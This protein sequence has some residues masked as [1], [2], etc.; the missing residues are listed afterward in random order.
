MNSARVSQGVFPP[1]SALH[2]WLSWVPVKYYL[3]VYAEGSGRRAAVRS[4]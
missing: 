2:G 3:G 4:L 1:N